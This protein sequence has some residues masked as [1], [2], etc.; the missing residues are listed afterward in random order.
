M[1]QHVQ[2]TLRK[3]RDSVDNSIGNHRLGTSSSARNGNI[4]ANT[5]LTPLQH[6]RNGSINVLSD[7]DAI[8]EV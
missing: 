1:E 4:R 7:G 8:A 5:I 6:T 3:L 2:R